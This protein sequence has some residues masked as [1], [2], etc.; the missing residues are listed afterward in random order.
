MVSGMSL[1]KKLVFAL[2]TQVRFTQYGPAISELEPND[3]MTPNNN[4]KKQGRCSFKPEAVSSCC[5]TSLLISNHYYWF[6][7][8]YLGIINS[9][10]LV[11]EVNDSYLNQVGHCLELLQV[12]MLLCYRFILLTRLKQKHWR[13]IVAFY[14]Q[15]TKGFAFIAIQSRHN[16]G[17]FSAAAMV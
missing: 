16:F 2:L 6:H 1:E 14:K 9:S 12:V 15:H 3:L 11:G 17:S 7:L 4:A 8:S 5:D 10:S 13:S